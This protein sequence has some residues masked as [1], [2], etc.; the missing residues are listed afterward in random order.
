MLSTTRRARSGPTGSKSCHARTLIRYDQRGCGLSDRSLPSFD[1]AACVEDLEAAVEA[2]G[3]KRFALFGMSQGGAIAVAYAARHPDRVS[4]LILVGAYGRGVMRRAVTAEQ[5]DEA[6][7]LLKLIRLGWGRE[8]PAFRQVFTS[9]FIPDGTREQH[10][11]FNDLERL[12]APAENAARIVEALYQLDVTQEAERLRV[13]TL[14]FHSRLD[15][16]VP[17]AEGQRL[18]TLIRSSRFVP[19]EGRNH[20]L[21]RQE[22]AWERFVEEF[23]AFLDTGSAIDTL[24]ESG[25]TASE[26]EVLSLLARG[27]DNAEIAKALAKSEKTVRNQV[28][29]IFAKLGVHTRAQAVAIA[30]DRGIGR[31]A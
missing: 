10:Q 12:S 30:R 26:R 24:G 22:P 7:T 29:S 15:E 3:L 6:E 18:A 2:P 19:L 5:R 4:H 9:Q 25:L 14:I 17:F 23:R 1:I 8:N 28:S 16:R 11:W 27:L 31:P 13:P 20:V 21:L